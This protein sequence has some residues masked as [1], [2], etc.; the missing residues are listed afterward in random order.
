VLSLFAPLNMGLEQR[1]SER[2]SDLQAAYQQVLP[3]GSKSLDTL[4]GVVAYACKASWA[5][6]PGDADVACPKGASTAKPSPRLPS[7]SGGVLV[8]TGSSSNSAV[9][10]MRLLLRSHDAGTAARSMQTDSDSDADVAA[11]AAAAA[12]EHAVTPPGDAELMGVAVK[13]LDVL[14]Q[15]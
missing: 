15:V 14:L 6:P 10:H 1:L 5:L 4:L 8:E 11:A 3:V 12:H 13:A 2:R 7:S 9:G